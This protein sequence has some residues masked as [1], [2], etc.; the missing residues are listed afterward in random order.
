MLHALLRAVPPFLKA[1]GY[2]VLVRLSQALRRAHNRR[3][4]ESMTGYS[5][6]VDGASLDRALCADPSAT[7]D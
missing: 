5:C 7:R 3:F 4:V 1:V 2:Q 6:P